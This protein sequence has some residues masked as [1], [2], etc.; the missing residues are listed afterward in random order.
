MCAAIGVDPLASGKGFWSE[1]L[2]VGDFYYELGVQIIE[3]CMATTHRNGG[4]LSLEELRSR[5]IASSGR[6]RQDV[7]TN[8]LL[9]AIRKLKVLG[10][11]FTLIPVAKG[12]YL[13]QSVPTELTMDHTTVLQQAEGSGYVTTESL[14]RDLSWES[15]RAHRALDYLVT[16]GLAW[17]DE[18]ARDTQYWFPG[19]FEACKD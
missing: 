15:D 7:S 3:V 4:L 6:N 11:G 16:E 10:N 18:Q 12:R 17:V 8:D 13:V 9:M 19:F 2:G 1:M 14:C 5:L